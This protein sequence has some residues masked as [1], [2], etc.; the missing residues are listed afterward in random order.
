MKC[1]EINSRKSFKQIIFPK[2][3]DFDTLKKRKVTFHPEK[4]NTLDDYPNVQGHDFES[5]FD[6]QKLLLGYARTGFQATHLAQAI[7]VIKTMRREKVK[8][9]LTFTSNM[10]SSGIRDIICYLVKHKLVDVLV[11]SAGGIEEDI[12]KIFAPFKIGHFDATAKSMY[13]NGIFRIGNI[14]VPN[15]RYAHYELFIDPLLETMYTE[16]KIWST[17]EFIARVGAAL[18]S[19]ENKETSYIYWAQKNNI[20]VFCP[21]LVDGCTGDLLYFFKYNHSDFVL[22][23]AGDAKLINDITL[24]AEKTGVICLGGGLPKHFAL[25]AQI[26]REGAEYAVYV[27]TAQEFDGSDSGGKVQEAQTWGKVKLNAMHVKVFVDATIAFPLIV[28]GAFQ[29]T[30]S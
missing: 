24:Q 4:L 27:N 30:L 28:A 25:N 29:D 22:D 23:T 21:G 3:M 12:M 1:Y 6:I 8:I 19:K 16:K 10:I 15:D 20:P 11:T 2:N 14:F 13:D 9:Y 17:N 7:N 5:S 26:L 18:E